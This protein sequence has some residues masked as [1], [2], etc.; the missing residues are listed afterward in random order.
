MIR[1][2]GGVLLVQG[3]SVISSR[4]IP[5]GSKLLTVC[6]FCGRSN[7]RV[8]G[9]YRHVQPVRR[10][11]LH[12]SA[13]IF[14]GGL[15]SE[16]FHRD[17]AVDLDGGGKRKRLNKSGITLTLTHSTFGDGFTYLWGFLKKQN[18]VVAIN[19]IFFFCYVLS[20]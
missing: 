17:L 13:W 10:L 16:R 5:M 15:Q 8:G 7:R 12:S 2:K 6:L 14:A 20:I 18:A 11:R 9:T 3:W 4:T 1:P 19:M